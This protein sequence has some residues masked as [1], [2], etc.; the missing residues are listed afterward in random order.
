MRWPKKLWR[1]ADDVCNCGGAIV[2]FFAR[3]RRKHC[4]GMAVTPSVVSR[5]VPL[6]GQSSH[7]CGMADGELTYDKEGGRNRGLS[8]DVE[9]TRRPLRIRPVVKGQIH[10][11]GLRLL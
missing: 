8:Q 11:L 4:P 3:R 5:L 2:N 6:C 7:Q 10:A 1:P 9:D